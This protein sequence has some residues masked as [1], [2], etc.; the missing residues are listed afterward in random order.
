MHWIA[1]SERDIATDTL[2]KRLWNTTD[3][4]RA[5]SGLTAAQHSAQVLGLILFAEIRFPQRHAAL[6]PENQ[7]SNST[8]KS[9]RML[10]V[11]YLNLAAPLL[12]GS[13]S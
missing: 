6:L 1:P 7:D 8:D 5:N 11:N 4:F 9:Y 3:Q 12:N 2:E 10:V 13:S